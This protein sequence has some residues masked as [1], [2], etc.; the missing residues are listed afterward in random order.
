MF[1]LLPRP[2]VTSCERSFGA[3]T[4]ER[5]LQG[6]GATGIFT[7]TRHSITGERRRGLQGGGATA[8]FMRTA[9]TISIPWTSLSLLIIPTV[10][11]KRYKGFSATKEGECGRA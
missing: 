3:G 10:S 11:H 2:S 7:R 5:G 8:I 4:D 6:G 1:P 9:S